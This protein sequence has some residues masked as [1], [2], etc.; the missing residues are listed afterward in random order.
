ME[1]KPEPF[2]SPAH[3]GT[4]AARDLSE[5]SGL[6]DLQYPS[7]VIKDSQA[8]VADLFG[9]ARSFY[10]VN[11]ASS[12]LHAAILALKNLASKKA[13]LLARNVHKSVLAAV[14]F[15]GLEIEWLEPE[16]LDDWAVYSSFA[17]DPVEINNNYAAVV[18]TNPSYE[19]F[20]SQLPKLEIPV[21]VDEAHGAH[22]HFSDVLPKPALECGADVVVQSWHKTLGSLTQ[23]GVL[24]VAK[25]SKLDADLI[26]DNLRLLNTTSPSYL[27]L[28]SLCSVAHTM[29]ERGKE[30]FSRAIALAAKIDFAHCAN[31]DPLRILFKLSD[32]PGKRLDDC[33][34]ERGIAL[35][36]YSSKA[37][38]AFVNYALGEASITKLNKVY[39]ELSGSLALAG[40][41]AQK[42]NGCL[43]DEG[44]T[45]PLKPVFAKQV[46]RPSDAFYLSEN[47]SLMLPVSDSVGC[48]AAE[49][50]APC[51]PGIPLLVPGQII[52]AENL[53][54]VKKDKIKVLK[55]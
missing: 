54:L 51:P 35:E 53:S 44:F 14:I 52:T 31:H 50:Y 9:A 30:I 40:L 47:D 45:A 39:A 6:D 8:F 29:K 2:H 20:Y 48:I 24:H 1:S 19:G 27:L 11:G 36:S 18:L 12:G 33:F 25:N 15:A 23:T 55:K 34:E 43:I 17:L 4:M 46:L 28:E 16:W 3:C 38:L 42:E 7:T 26:A 49:L 22:Y 32:L 41:Q 37:A 10:L 21:I 13:V 5:L